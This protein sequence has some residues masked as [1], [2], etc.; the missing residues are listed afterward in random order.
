MYI[1][2]STTGIY[3]LSAKNN[4]FSASMHSTGRS[5]GRQAFLRV[6]SRHRPSACHREQS[7]CMTEDW[8]E[9]AYPDS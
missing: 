3:K 7:L 5:R 4:W 6:A 9:S 1:A 2:V 8:G